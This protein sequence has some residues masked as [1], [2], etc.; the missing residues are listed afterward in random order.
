MGKYG[1]EQQN[2]CKEQNGWTYTKVV[3]K[4]NSYKATVTERGLENFILH[5][6]VSNMGHLPVV[7]NSADEAMEYA[8]YRGIKDY[9][10]KYTSGDNIVS[11]EVYLVTNGKRCRRCQL[12]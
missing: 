8:S 4:F 7:F 3:S 9:E 12:I 10:V 6:E 2:C 11:K 1:K 5:E